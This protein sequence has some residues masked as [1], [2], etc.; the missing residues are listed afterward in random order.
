MKKSVKVAVALT[1]V[2]AIAHSTS[3][4]Q[5]AGELPPKYKS[6]VEALKS[7]GEAL[8]RTERPS[9]LGA[10]VGIDC[11]TKFGLQSINVPIPEVTMNLQEIILHVP[12][13]KWA[14]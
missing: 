1:A 3:F 8:K 2:A 12:E 13:F 6:R 7:K 4:A 5:T 10:T 14:E 9:A 11:K